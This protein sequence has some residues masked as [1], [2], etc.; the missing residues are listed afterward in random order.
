VHWDVH[1][2]RN[3]HPIGAHIYA[4]SGILA[5][6]LFTLVVD[7]SRGFSIV[8]AG[9]QIAESASW[10]LTVSWLWWARRLACSV[11]S[12]SVRR[13]RGWLHSR[14]SVCLLL[15]PAG[16]YQDGV[17]MGGLPGVVGRWRTRWP[18]SR[19]AGGCAITRHRRRHDQPGS[20]LRSNRWITS[21][22]PSPVRPK[23][24]SR[25]AD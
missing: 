20:P 12:G 15:R 7:R 21:W 2:C 22:S 17:S 16:E 11:S 19:G 6:V 3:E 5:H 23:A 4:R 25:S 14:V 1:S 18:R 9:N 10:A 24:C 8:L 13:R